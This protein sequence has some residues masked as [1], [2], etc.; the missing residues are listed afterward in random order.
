MALRR[1]MLKNNLKNSKEFVYFDINQ[2]NDNNWYAWY[3]DVISPES[4]L[5]SGGDMS[6]GDQR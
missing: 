5:K 6:D 3:N 2:S 1:L 4:Q